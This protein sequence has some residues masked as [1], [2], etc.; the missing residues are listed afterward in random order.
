MKELTIASLVLAARPVVGAIQFAND[1]Q[2]MCLC[3]LSQIGGYRGTELKE[4][5]CYWV[6]NVGSKAANTALAFDMDVMVMILLN[7]NT[8]WR[9]DRHIV[10]ARSVEKY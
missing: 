1:T 5:G 6:G 9:V 7:A 10:H 2:G 3:A 4:T 8:A